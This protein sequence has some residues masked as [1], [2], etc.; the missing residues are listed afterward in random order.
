MKRKLWQAVDEAGGAIK[1]LA[2]KLRIIAGYLAGLLVLTGM[3]AAIIFG[4]PMIA[5]LFMGD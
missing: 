3:F 1:W 4:V 2:A 5:G